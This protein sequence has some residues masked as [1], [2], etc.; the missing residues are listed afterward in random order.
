MS[1]ETKVKERPIIF[2]GEMVRAILDG[3]KTMTRRVVK[4]QPLPHTEQYNHKTRKTE[5]PPGWYENVAARCKYG[6]PG[7]RLWVRETFGLS[8]QADDVNSR[9]QVVVYRAGHPY[10]ITDVGVDELKRCKNGEL[11][12][13]NHFVPKPLRWYPS[14][15]MP[16]WASRITMEIVSVRAERL[17]DIS[18]SDGLDE[19][20]P[21]Y[22]LPDGAGEGGKWHCPTDWFRDLWDSLSG[23][24]PGCSWNDNPWVWVIEFKRVDE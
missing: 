16:R 22:D 12:E 14:I 18:E 23:K 21:I 19:G 7:D 5:H 24:K 10:A 20:A 8:H 4:P 11:M 1:N 6:V 13:P 2:S 3:R 9:E 17:Q 15:Y